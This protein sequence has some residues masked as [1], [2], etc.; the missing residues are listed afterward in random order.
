MLI[1]KEW[2]PLPLKTHL[3]VATV[4]PDP[5]VLP[6]S[7]L[8]L[9]LKLEKPLKPLRL[10]LKLYKP[11]KL[12]SVKLITIPFIISAFKALFLHH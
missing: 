3:S 6:K 8:T 11:F 1:N 2:P 4:D 5:R 12:E 10:P 7:L 9:L